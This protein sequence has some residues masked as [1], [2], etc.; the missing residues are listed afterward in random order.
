MKPLIGLTTY[1]RN[2]FDEDTPRFCTPAAYCDAVARAGGV[3]VLIPPCQPDFATLASRFDG[4]VLIGGGDVDPSHYGG[5]SH[6]TIY[7][8]DAERDG[9][10]LGFARKLAQSDLPALCICRGCQVLNV[11]LGG[12]L[13]EHLPDEVGDELAH[14][15]PPRKPTEHA[16]TIEPDSKLAGLI[17]GTVCN[18]IS[19]HH[20]AVRDVAK[21]LKVVARASD[22]TIEAVELPDHPFMVAVQW[23][24][25]LAAERDPIQQGLFDR[26]VEAARSRRQ[27]S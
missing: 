7:M 4:F 10:E 16:V 14:R 2:D 5:R 12:T 8:T 18:T 11:A 20:Q 24:P 9:W 21:P 17:G 27:K 26:L 19:W 13:V 3:P 6:E 15:D 25:E 1:G 22:G 23:H